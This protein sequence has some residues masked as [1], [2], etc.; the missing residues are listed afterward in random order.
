MSEDPLSTCLS[1]ALTACCDICAGI[2]IDFA[3]VRHACTERLC[4]W[5]NCGTQKRD[6]TDEREPLIENAEPA[7]RRC[8][9]VC[10]EAI[11]R[12]AML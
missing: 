9:S 10:L 12:A 2:C 3:S 6:D 5:G 8:C 11:H 1:V 7:K 4:V